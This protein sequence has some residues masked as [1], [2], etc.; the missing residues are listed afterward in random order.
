MLGKHS[1]PGNV[2][3]LE[4]VLRRA[5]VNMNIADTQIRSGHLPPLGSPSHPEGL[6]AT[7]TD[8][9]IPLPSKTLPQMRREWERQVLSE[10]LRKCGGSRSRA[11]Q[12]LGISIRSMH[13]KLSQYGL[14]GTDEPGS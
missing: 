9:E 2:R 10:A 8:A 11:A 13:H 14:R 4:N 3:E 7:P 1:W 6:E 12:M 5:V